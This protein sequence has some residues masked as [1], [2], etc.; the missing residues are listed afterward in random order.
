MG[1]P[2]TP[3]LPP[4]WND[5]ATSKQTRLL[6]LGV[7]VCL[8][9]YLCWHFYRSEDYNPKEKRFWCLQVWVFPIFGAL[10]ALPLVLKDRRKGKHW[11][12]R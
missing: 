12:N 2:L 7:V 6:G 5:W 9:L 3:K 11:S 10:L 8:N 4:A 1:D